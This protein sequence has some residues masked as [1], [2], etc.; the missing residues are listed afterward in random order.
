MSS[1]LLTC[2]KSE[3]EGFKKMFLKNTDIE[4]KGMFDPTSNMLSFR[5]EFSKHYK[6]CMK[7]LWS[8]LASFSGEE[9]QTIAYMSWKELA[10]KMPKSK[11]DIDFLN[12]ILKE[13]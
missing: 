13:K 2:E 6:R 8:S 7:N 12:T 1:L 3:E 11:K 4:K 10:K 5:P 9:H